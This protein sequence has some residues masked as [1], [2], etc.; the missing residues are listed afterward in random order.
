MI[1]L[2]GYPGCFCAGFSC[3]KWGLLSSCGARASHFCDFSCCRAQASAVMT[4]GLSSRFPGSRAQAQLWCMG[5]VALPY[6]APS[7]IRDGTHLFCFGGQILYTEPPGKPCAFFISSFLSF[8]FCFLIYIIF[9][10]SVHIYY[11]Y[12]DKLM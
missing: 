10:E 5:L 9:Q 1:Y 8:Y 7:Q 12:M 2:S 4:R 11:L 3:G 6:V